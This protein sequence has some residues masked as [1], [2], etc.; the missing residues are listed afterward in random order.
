MS[1]LIGWTIN[2]LELAVYFLIELATT[3]ISMG[4]VLAMRAGH[5]IY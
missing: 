5:Y 4:S 2:L 1:L 3:F